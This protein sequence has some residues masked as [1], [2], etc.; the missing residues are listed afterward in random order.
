MRLGERGNNGL[1]AQSTACPA[2]EHMG[3]PWFWGPSEHSKA[4]GSETAPV[5]GRTPPPHPKGPTQ[6]KSDASGSAT[7]HWGVQAEVHNV[8]GISA[9][10]WAP[11][12]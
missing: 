9:L 8:K 4:Q 5:P 1:L 3:T 7:C 10:G 11:F 6:G 12:H 2:F